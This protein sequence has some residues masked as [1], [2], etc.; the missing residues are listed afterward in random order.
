MSSAICTAA[1]GPSGARNSRETSPRASEASAAELIRTTFLFR[2][3]D[4]A[5]LGAALDDPTTWRTWLVT[6][7]AAFGLEL[8]AEELRTFEAIAGTRK[9]PEKRVDEL[10]ALIGRGGGKSRVAGLISVYISCF[11]PHKLARGETGHVLVLA[12]SRDQAQVVFGYCDGFLQ[13][14]AILRQL[15]ASRTAF[16]IR[17]TNG[18]VLAVHSNS[19]RHIRGRS[20]IACVFDEVA[21]WRDEQAACPDVETYRAVLPSLMR[22]GGMLIGISTPYRRSGLLFDKF[23]KHFDVDGDS[24][25]V[26]RGGTSAF[27][28]QIDQGKIAKAMLADPEAARSEWQAEFRSD[29]SALFDEGVIDDAVDHA[30]PLELPPRLSRK[31]AAFADA[32]A[33]RNDAFSF[34]IGHT[35]GPKE[36]ARWICDAIRARAAPFNPRD[37]AEE[38]ASLA[39]QYGCHKLSATRLPANGYQRFRR[40]RH[41]VRNVPAAQVAALP[42]GAA[43]FQPR[44]GL[45]AG[46]R[47]VA[48]RAAHARATS[49]QIRKRLVD[50]PRNGADDLANAVCGALYCAMSDVHRP[51]ARMGAIAFGTTGKVTWKD[52]EKDAP[53]P[54]HRS[55]HRGRGHQNERGGR[56]RMVRSATSSSCR[57]LA[58]AALGGAWPCRQWYPGRTALALKRHRPLI[59]AARKAGSPAKAI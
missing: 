14:S 45:P 5:L 39:R 16:E 20:L 52:D 1:S 33:G 9:P 10:W 19:F 24:I 8:H 59:V 29:L 48:A 17:L 21:F 32:S 53:A 3:L 37:V 31:Y 42:R 49:A 22:M 40:C 56:W 4:P 44:R 54:P 38:Y 47:Q 27:N 26:V 34:C 12:G 46:A 28:P 7:K 41:P 50:H 15:V 23:E 6:L 13:S 36:E 2:L 18:I 57:Q 58:G 11:V 30:R 51:R 35:E 43:V 25:L 55:C